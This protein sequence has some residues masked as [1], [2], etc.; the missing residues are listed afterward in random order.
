M[1]ILIVGA[2]RIGA[3][4]PRLEEHGA[5]RITHWPARNRKVARNT[6]PVHVDAVLFFTDF[7]HHTAAR[8]LKSQAKKLGLPCLHCRRCWSE[9]EGQLERLAQ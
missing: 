5:S 1:S 4:V 8:K 7:L 6:I 2:D 3:L 9:M